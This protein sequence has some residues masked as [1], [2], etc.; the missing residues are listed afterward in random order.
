MKSAAER[1]FAGVVALQDVPFEAPFTPAREVGWRFAYDHWG[2][3]YATEGAR[4][5]LDFAFERLGWHE[6]VAFTAALNLRSQKVMERLG[7][8]HDPNDD[9]DHPRIPEGDPLRRHLLYRASRIVAHHSHPS[10]SPFDSLRSLRVTP[11]GS[12]DFARCARFA[13]DDMRCAPPLRMTLVHG[14]E[15]RAG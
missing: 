14:F 8:T 7:M 10:Q 2:H 5:A 1:R 3:G 13:Q 9:F 4:A 6:V 11:H 15:L 12:F